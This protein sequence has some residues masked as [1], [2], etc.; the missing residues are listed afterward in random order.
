MSS[1]CRF[2][3]NEERYIIDTLNT[4]NDRRCRL[5]GGEPEDERYLRECVFM[6]RLRDLIEKLIVNRRPMEKVFTGEEYQPSNEE[7]NEI[8]MAIKSAVRASLLNTFDP[9][10]CI[11]RKSDRKFNRQYEGTQHFTSLSLFCDD[12]DTLLCEL[13]GDVDR[14]AVDRVVDAVHSIVYGFTKYVRQD[15]WKEHGDA[16]VFDYLFGFGWTD[17]E[18][19]S[20]SDWRR[21]MQAKFDLMS[22]VRE[23]AANPSAFSEYTIEFARRFDQR[24]DCSPDSSGARLFN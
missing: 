1:N 22:R 13:Y 15:L 24:W 21:G 19:Y 3:L 12:V 9:A 18:G 23:V 10:A 7:A 5:P 17:G 14:E 11:Q 6:L 16:V 8:C 20:G 4:P 2:V